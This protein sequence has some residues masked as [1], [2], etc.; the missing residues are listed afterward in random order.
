MRAYDHSRITARLLN[1]MIQ[2]EL[3]SLPVNLGMDC[4]DQRCY[5]SEGNRNQY[6]YTP[7]SSLKRN[8]AAL[9]HVRSLRVLH[10]ILEEV[11]GEVC[12]F[13]FSECQ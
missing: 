13:R 5:N 8:V 10:V 4:L 9:L 2:Y 12:R 7:S 6:R 11:T 3:T 1:V